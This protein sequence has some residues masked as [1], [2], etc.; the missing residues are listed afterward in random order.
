M[1]EK[2]RSPLQLIQYFKE[3]RVELDKV[4]WPSR[5]QT[6]EKTIMVVVVSIAVGLYIGGLDLLFTWLTKLFI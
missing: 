4:T 3:V 5:E 6:I 2:L 1:L